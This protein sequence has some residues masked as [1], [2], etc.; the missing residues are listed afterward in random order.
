MSTDTDSGWFILKAGFKVYGCCLVCASPA[1]S[2]Y[3]ERRNG[4]TGISAV[5]TG[6]TPVCIDC[7]HGLPIQTTKTKKKAPIL[8]KTKLVR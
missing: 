4:L 7:G 6:L 8:Y 2:Y 1:I 3:K 5:S